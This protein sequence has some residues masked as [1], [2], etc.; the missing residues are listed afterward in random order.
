MAMAEGVSTL[1]LVPTGYEA[2]RLDLEPGSFAVCGFGLAAAGVGAAR[3]FAERQPARAVL[4]GTAGTYDAERAPIG[5][6]LVASAVRC[7]GIGAGDLSAAELGWAESDVVELDGGD[8]EL[9]SVAAAS[10][11][12]DAAARRAAQHPAAVAEEMEGFAVALAARA[13]GVELSV[14]RGISNLAG[15]RDHARWRMTEALAAARRLLDTIP[16]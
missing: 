6:A 5:S 9:L 10:P 4:L 11:S 1:V 16:A 2:A 3:A 14:V 12:C 8:G 7:V 13:F 15:D